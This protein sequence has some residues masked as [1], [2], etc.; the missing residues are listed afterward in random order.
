MLFTFALAKRLAAERVTVNAV[1]PGRS[2][3]QMTHSMRPATMGLPRP[4]WPVLR[5]LQRAGS[6]T[7]SAPE[8]EGPISTH[9]YGADIERYTDAPPPTR[10]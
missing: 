4:L 8:A 2:W 3:T 1:H 5:L 10:A 7:S 6:P 9:F